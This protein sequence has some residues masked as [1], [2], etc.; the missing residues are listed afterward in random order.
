MRAYSCKCVGAKKGPGSVEHGLEWLDSLTKIV[1]DP[2]RCPYAAK[3][4][5]SIDYKLDKD[6]NTLPQLE[7]KNDHSIDCLRYL[8]EPLQ[9]SKRSFFG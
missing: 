6:G 9:H 3:E 7:D 1:I 2:K 4:F 8:T 5:E